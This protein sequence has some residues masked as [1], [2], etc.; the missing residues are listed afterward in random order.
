MAGLGF[1]FGRIV[2]L[3]GPSSSLLEGTGGSLA[4]K[5]SWAW[6]LPWKL[7]PGFHFCL[8]GLFL[9]AIY[10]SRLAFGIAALPL[11]LPTD[12]GSTTASDQGTWK[13]LQ[14]LVWVLV[15]PLFLVSSLLS[16]VILGLPILISSRIPA[17]AHSDWFLRIS[18][19]I[20]GLGFLAVASWIAGKGGRQT[21]RKAIRL[22]EPK[23]IG[24]SLAI[25]IGIATLLST[26]QYLFERAQWTAH[27]VGNT[28]PLQF[29]S[30]FTFPDPWLLLHFFPRK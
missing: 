9:I 25:P 22:P 15:G 20:E 1:I 6:S 12:P 29:G 2:Y 7:L 28:D 21:I 30:Y 10:T 3:F 19:V 27:N 17:Y 26:G 11:S 13:Q 5:M 8:I 18:S 14:Y 24:L 23:N 4:H 16:F